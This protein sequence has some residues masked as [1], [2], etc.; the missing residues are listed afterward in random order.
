MCS[1]TTYRQDA[2]SLAKLP[3]EISWASGKN[4]GD[5]DAFTVFASNDVETKTCGTTLEH[6]PPGFP[7]ENAIQTHFFLF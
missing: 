3:T 6:N 1:D 2:V 5:E 7:R 4:K